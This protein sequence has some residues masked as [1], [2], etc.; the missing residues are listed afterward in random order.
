MQTS[1]S[2]SLVDASAGERE[3]IA[4]QAKKPREIPP[5]AVAIVGGAHGLTAAASRRSAAKAS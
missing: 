5:T 1:R 4:Y 3:T 2:S